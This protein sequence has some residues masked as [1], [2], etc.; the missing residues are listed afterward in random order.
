MSNSLWL[1][2]SIFHNIDSEDEYYGND[3]E[4]GMRALWRSVITQALMDAS[5]NS[6]KKSDKM[7]KIQAIQ[8]LLDDSSDFA[9]VCGLADMDSHY[10][11]DQA[12]AALSRGCKW[13][14]DHKK[15]SNTSVRY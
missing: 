9:A 15:M 12:R 1:N 6:K 2:Q 10:V 13:R 5:S 7:C 14:D 4:L 3:E 11:R 8:W